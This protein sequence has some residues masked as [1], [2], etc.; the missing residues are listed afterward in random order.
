MHCSQPQEEVAAPGRRRFL[1][2]LLGG[3]LFASAVSFFYPVL[4]Y[5][6]PPRVTDMGGDT[7]VAGKVGELRPNSGKIFRFGSRPGLLLLGADGQ[8]R[9]LSATCT[10]LSCTVQY[11]GDLR[12]V[13]CAC[14]NGMYDLAGRNLSGPPPRPLEQY[15]VHVRGDEI[16]VSR[17][18]EA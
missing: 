5:L 9:A 15:D 11:R 7:V 17:R 8:Y 18:R 2:M 14:H 3:G 1:G 12:Q 10:H 4:R 16:I 6:V 13:W